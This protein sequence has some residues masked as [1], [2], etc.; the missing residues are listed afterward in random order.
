MLRA[1]LLKT[2]A[3]PPLR[4]PLQRRRCWRQG[5]EQHAQR[6]PPP[7]PREADAPEWVG[8]PDA[9]TFAWPR[10][11]SA[12]ALSNAWLAFHAQA[13]ANRD[14]A[15][16]LLLAMRMRRATSFNKP[17]ASE[18]L[19]KHKDAQGATDVASQRVLVLAAEL[20]A[21]GEPAAGDNAVVD[22]PPT[23][24]SPRSHLHKG[25]RESG[26]LGTSPSVGPSRWP[27]RCH[28]KRATVLQRWFYSKE[29]CVYCRDSSKCRCWGH[30]CA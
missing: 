17:S 26:T 28:F 9:P 29:E 7:P 30:S 11:G 27:Q 6:S 21:S 2:Q 22:S 15:E 12:G 14:M 1:Q 25:S 19:C 3:S 4:G 5:P 18:L 20:N 13:L 24:P 8:S 16:A 10:S 23:T